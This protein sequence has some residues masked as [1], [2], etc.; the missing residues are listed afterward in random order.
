MKTILSPVQEPL[1]LLYMLSLAMLLMLQT[2]AQVCSDPANVIYGLTNT[3][4][5]YPITIS[6]GAVGAQLNPAY[7]GNP[8]NLSN[9]IGYNALNG[10]FYYFKRSPDVAPM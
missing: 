4:L 6:T 7:T 9:G 1:P 8:A 5:I 10:K 3:G 2:S